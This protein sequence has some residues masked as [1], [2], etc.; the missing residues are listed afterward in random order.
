MH[1]KVVYR[2]AKS[3]AALGWPVLRFNFRGVGASEGTF[4][5]GAGEAADVRAALDWLAE[6]SGLPIVGTGFSFGSI[7]GLPV[8]AADARVS[9][10]VG[11]GIP[12]DRFPFEALADTSKPKLFIQGEHDEFGPLD[13]LRTGL[14]RVAEPLRLEVVEDAD[15]FFTDRL[16]ALQQAITD[17]FSDTGGREG[18]RDP[19]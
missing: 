13:A 3:F 19:S 5:D 11:I 18:V 14:E 1:N 2:A 8:G 9:H 7:V 10:L 15:H 12:T 6:R 4:G 16:E 17:Y